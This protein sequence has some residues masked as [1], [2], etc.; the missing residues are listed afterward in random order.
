MGKKVCSGVNGIDAGDMQACLSGETF[1][2]VSV[3]GCDSIKT[4]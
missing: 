3:E 2:G 4:L 1:A